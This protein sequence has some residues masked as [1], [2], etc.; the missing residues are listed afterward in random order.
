MPWSTP[1]PIADHE[2]PKTTKPF[3]RTGDRIT[4]D[5]AG[6]IAIQSERAHFPPETFRIS[7]K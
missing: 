7:T 5:E 4:L 3:V 2:C 1:R 6:R